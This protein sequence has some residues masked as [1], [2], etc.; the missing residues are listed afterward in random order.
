MSPLILIIFLPSAVC[1]FWLITN[2]YLARRTSTFTVLE[3]FSVATLLYF[4]ADGCYATPGI[5]PQ[6]LVYSRMFTVGAGS[7]LVPIIWMYFYKLLHRGEF[8]PAQFLWI[9]APVSLVIAGVVFTEISDKSAIAVFLSELFGQGSSIVSAY[10]G[11]SLWHFYIWTRIVFMTVVA[12]ELL[13]ATIYL[14]RYVIKEKVRFGNLWRYWF[15]GG[16]I[17]VTELQIYNLLVIAIYI[18][19]KLMFLK[20]F[21]DTH[22]WLSVILALLVSFGYSSLMY[23]SLFGEK[24]RITLV[25]TKHVMFYNYNPAIKGPIVEIMLEELLEDSGPEILSRLRGKLGVA[26]RTGLKNQIE[27]ASVKDRLMASA[28]GAWDDSLIARFRALMIEEQ[29]F[30]HPSL[31]LTDVAERLRTNKTYIS[32]LVNNTYDM[33]FPELLNVLR[34]DYAEQ[35]LMN[36]KNAKQ[37]DVAKVSGFLSA[38]SFNS[39]FKKVTGVTPKVW[40]ASQENSKRA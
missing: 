16:S 38:S 39:I 6:I 30:L 10:K 32:K 24:E 23:C 12:T 14:L 3:C 15:K 1:L 33:G 19:V 18:A 28:S 17:R 21:L 22:I 20:S 29:L 13:A 36:H 35:Y 37:E 11:T 26:G 7:C 25:Q 40:L 4:L 27:V 31:S 5:D 9:I 8:R 2:F 34:I